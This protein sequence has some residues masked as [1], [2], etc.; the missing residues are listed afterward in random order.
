[1]YRLWTDGKPDLQQRTQ[2]MTLGL[3][4][5][6]IVIGLGMTLFRA[7]SSVFVEAELTSINW[8]VWLLPVVLLLAAAAWAA[9]WQTGKANRSDAMQQHATQH[10]ASVSALTVAEVGIVFAHLNDNARWA[11]V[12]AGVLAILVGMAWSWLR[13][14]KRIG[15]NNTLPTT[16]GGIDP[17]LSTRTRAALDAAQ[18]DG[19]IQAYDRLAI[20]PSP[21]GTRIIVRLHLDPE[22]SLTHARDTARQVERSIESLLPAGT[23][24]TLLEPAIGHTAP[25]ARVPDTEPAPDTDHEHSDDEA[26]PPV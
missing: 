13:L 3:V 12:L 6:L 2:T 8:A 23:V 11:D 16:E 14:W 25:P 7:A 4:G 24:I 9:A 26:T 10:L 20:E 5:W 21:A 18:T 1:L 15:A 17:E 19:L 22:L